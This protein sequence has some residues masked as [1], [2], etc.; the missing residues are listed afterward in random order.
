MPFRLDEAFSQ[1]ANLA[2]WASHHYPQVAAV[3]VDTSVYNHAGANA[4]QELASCL[5]TGVAYL[6]VM[7]EAG[8]EVNAAVRQMELRLS[9]GTHHFL[10]IAK[11]RA[12]RLLWTRVINVCGGDGELLPKINA[13]TSNR[14]FTRRE[15]ANNILRN[16]AAMFAACVGGA[17]VVTSVP[18]D[19]TAQLPC[20]QPSEKSRRIARNTVLLLQQEAHLRRVSDPAH[21]SWFLETATQQLAEAAWQLFQTIEGRG[22]MHAVLASGWWHEQIKATNQRWCDDMA[23]CRESLIGVNAFVD[24]GAES[25]A[26]APATSLPTMP[27]NRTTSQPDLPAL[28]PSQLTA[29]VEAAA[30]G[31]TMG[32]LSTS[33]GFQTAAVEIAPLEAR[34]LAQPFEDLRDATDRWFAEH[35][36]RPGAFV[37]NFGPMSDTA[38]QATFAQRILEVAVVEVIA[39]GEVFPSLPLAV[40]A[41]KQSGASIAVVCAA[42]EMQPELVPH[43]AT[44]LKQAGARTVLLVGAPGPQREQWRSAGVDDFVFEHCPVLALLQDLLKREGVM[45]R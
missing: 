21:G 12:V 45:P 36:Q 29:A 22:G 41:F 28:S 7:T 11:L 18:F 23:Q 40:A 19:N 16:S 2:Q 14:V 24:L 26:T 31:A 9:L 34:S 6:R 42:E 8:M 3:C 10:E 1:L 44:Q 43:A 20:E 5:A 15:P 37:V 30:E 35:G 38:K 13:T 33:L 39:S 27:Q 32:Q 4:V 17:D 25:L